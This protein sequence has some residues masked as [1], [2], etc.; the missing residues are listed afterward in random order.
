[1]PTP[2]GRSELQPYSPTLGNTTRGPGSGR[3]GPSS[4]DPCPFSS[5]HWPLREGWLCA[6]SQRGQGWAHRW[7]VGRCQGWCYL[8][9]RNVCARLSQDRGEAPWPLR[10]SASH[11]KMG[12]LTAPAS[13]FVMRNPRAG[14]CNGMSTVPGILKG[15][16]LQKPCC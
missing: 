11:L 5:G 15:F 10:G 1:M 3:R 6:I 12:V 9:V 2:V 8:V 7:A 13:R 4:S 14:V 16:G